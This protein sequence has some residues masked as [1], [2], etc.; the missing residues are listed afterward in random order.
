[1]SLQSS[2]VFFVKFFP[3]LGICA[4][5]RLALCFSKLAKTGIQMNPNLKLLSLFLTFC[6]LSSYCH[7]FQQEYKTRKFPTTVPSDTVFE[8]DFTCLMKAGKFTLTSGPGRFRLSESG[9][10]HWRPPERFQGNE[11]EIKFV[12]DRKGKLTGYAYTLKVSKRGERK[13]VL[14]SDEPSLVALDKGEFQW[15][16]DP[17]QS[18]ERSSGSF[19]DVYGSGK[20]LILEGPVQLGVKPDGSFIWM[21][22]FSERKTVKLII[23][24]IDESGEKHFIYAKLLWMERYARYKIHKPALA[25]K[26][27]EPTVYPTTIPTSTEFIFDFTSEIEPGKFTLVAGPA[28]LKL[29]E[30]GGVSGFRPG[31][32]SHGDKTEVKFQVDRAGELS[33]YAYLFEF[34]RDRPHMVAGA[35]GASKKSN[36][37]IAYDWYPESIQSGTGFRANLSRMAGKGDFLLLEG[38]HG[39]KISPTGEMEWDPRNGNMGIQKVIIR[40]NRKPKSERLIYIKFLVERHPSR[41]I[42]SRLAATLKRKDAKPRDKEDLLHTVIECPRPGGWVISPDG[43][44]LVVSDP[45]EA[46]LIYFDT[47]KEKEIRRVEVDFQPNLLAFHR[48]SIVASSKGSS[49]I[50]VLNA[51]N[52]EIKKEI[53][54]GSEAIVDLACHPKKGHVY[55]SNSKYEILFIDI[56]KD[57]ATTTNAKGH[58]LAVDPTAGEYL[59]AGIQ[60]RNPRELKVEISEEGDTTTFRFFRDTWGARAAMMRYQVKGQR[61]KL[62]ETQDNAAVNGRTMHLTP[63]GKRIMMIG[64]GGWRPKTEGTGG[65]YITAIFRSGNLDERVGQIPSG[66]NVIFH[67]ILK[68]GIIND[69]GMQLKPFRDKAYVLK[70]AIVLDEKFEPSYEPSPLLTFCDKGRKVAIWNGSDINQ[71]KGLH[72]IPL[73]LT[74]QEKKKLR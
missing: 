5:D 62:L 24:R 21:L 32:G 33:Y 9:I 71:R 72:I 3:T 28:G 47:R 17:F 67:P 22:N 20:Y 45:A 49:V 18:G 59:Y 63:D 54:T 52:G 16:P 25:S 15:Y 73:P 50:R 64:G 40:Q 1:M 43:K 6:L 68:M 31:N 13:A 37:D 12:V 10:T 30:T 74:E 57:K 66:S 70:P 2:S 36:E 23:Q 19:A 29:S 11:Y 41:K 8:F 39:F 69:G 44:T 56:E 55:A 7:A 26:D 51:K 61:L 4:A 42:Q 14:S 38:P 35:A 58:F 48:G 53:R 34:S 60:P 65:G 27:F 46:Q